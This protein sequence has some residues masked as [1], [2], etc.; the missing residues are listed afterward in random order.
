MRTNTANQYQ[1]KFERLVDYIFANLAGDLDLMTLAEVAC[2]SPYHLHRLYRCQFGETLANT[3]KRIRL[4]YAANG[5]LNSEQ[6]IEKIAS[7]S[8]FGS[9][10]A[11]SRAF[12]LA[13]GMP[14]SAFRN[15]GSL[16]PF[17][18]SRLSE[19]GSDYG[20]RF[21]QLTEQVVYG[22]PHSGSFL[23]IGQ[24]F[25]RLFGLLV[26]HNRLAEAETVCGVYWDDPESTEIKHLRSLAGVI[27]PQFAD[28]PDLTQQ[29][30]PAG[31]YVVLRFKGPYVHLHKAYQWL[32]GE[33]LPS[34]SYVP[35]NTPVLERY[36]NNPRDVRP[37]ELLTDIYL[38]IEK[39]PL[40]DG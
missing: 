27:Q 21:E 14:P 15:Q 10:Q 34:A 4:H 37:S 36:I 30:M 18:L 25:E 38:Q 6:A 23:D 26:K 8:G 16:Q 2:L 32:F 7:A 29:T 28:L 13:Y 12:K 1:R 17:A 20:L 5:L 39:E 3:I 33:W 31:Q 9:V 40:S 11:F 19:S 22:L 35:T 24:T